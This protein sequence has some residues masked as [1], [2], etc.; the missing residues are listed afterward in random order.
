MPI[1][2]RE[3]AIALL[4]WVAYTD[5]ALTESEAKHATVTYLMSENDENPTTID[6]DD[7]MSA[8]DLI[9][10]CAG[11][12][13]IEDGRIIPVHYT[14]A[15]YLKNTQAKWFPLVYDKL[16]K[17]CLTYLLFD[18]FS[19]GPL[20]GDTEYEE[21]EMRSQEF[22]LLDYASLWWGR[23]AHHT[24]NSEVRKMALKFLN[25]NSHRDASI[26]ALWYPTNIAAY[27][28][29]A[30]A[31]ATGLHLASYF[32]LTHLVSDLLEGDLYPGLIDVQDSL[33]DTALMYAATEGHE[34]ILSQLLQSGASVQLVS[35]D[36]CN[37]L[38]RGAAYGHADVV[39]TLLKSSDLD[40]NGFKRRHNGRNALILAVIYADSRVVEVLL[41]R[42]DLQPNLRTSQIPPLLCL[43]AFRG[44]VDIF[45]LLLND[46]RVKEVSLNAQNDDGDTA[47]MLAA[48]NGST[49]VAKALL[50][51]GADTNISNSYERGEDTAF[52][53]AARDGHIPI[54]RL[55]LSRNLDYTAKNRYQRTIL[56]NAAWAGRDQVLQMV[57][58]ETQ[59]LD[60]NLQDIYGCTALHEWYFSTL[61]HC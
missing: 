26:Q 43:A 21:F 34:Q 6:P 41:Q 23:F 17:A 13:I 40:V 22:P 57:L 56:H 16:T 28:W 14:A 38:H 44:D 47:L 30:K 18:D 29:Q 12:V 5:R 61:N 37:V 9:S 20:A 55:F 25:S 8:D 1:D 42:E 59:A 53:C 48:S 19:G 3:I 2:H 36:G 31:G 49:S 45:E 35:N 27:G 51:A 32:G 10:L 60:I 50:D 46:E 11:L 52:L 4:S 58:E 39:R 33:G 15:T 7:I 54:I 24:Q